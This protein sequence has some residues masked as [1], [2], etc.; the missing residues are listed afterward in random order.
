M[1]YRML[2]VLFF[3]PVQIILAQQT[4]VQG[5][6]TDQLTG[7]PMSFVK[8]FFLDSKIGTFTDSLGHYSIETYYATDSL[9]FVFTGYLSVTR[10]IKK[11]VEQELS[12]VLPI[13]TADIEE[14]VARAPDELPSTRLHKRVIANKPIN[15]KE[16]LSAY[17]YEL[18]NKIQFYAKNIG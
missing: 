13:L 6:V 4:K 16:K 11:D 5:I 17:E 15:N 9:R 1:N 7:E 12:I 10:K 2:L 14:V 8:V 3:F 18:Y